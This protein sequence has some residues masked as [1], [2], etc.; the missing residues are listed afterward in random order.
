MTLQALGA[1]GEV[2]WLLDGRLQGSSEGTQP[3]TITLNHAGAR[4]ITA[5]ARNGAFAAIDVRVIDSRP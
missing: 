5:L 1:Q 4:R 3:M 2:Q